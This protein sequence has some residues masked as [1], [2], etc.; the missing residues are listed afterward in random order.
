MSLSEASSFFFFFF[1][2]LT[3]NSVRSRA[4]LPSTMNV[5]PVIA[6]AIKD[7]FSYTRMDSVQKLLEEA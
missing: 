1:V 3:S 2:F 7:H 5:S 6:S 4:L